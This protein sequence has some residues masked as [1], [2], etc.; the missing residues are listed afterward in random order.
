MDEDVASARAAHTPQ[1]VCNQQQLGVT[2]EFVQRL[3]RPLA[4]ARPPLSDGSL[5]F[6][7][8]LF[9]IN[10]VASSSTM[11]L[12]LSGDF[13]ASCRGQGT[14]RLIESVTHSARKTRGARRKSFN[15]EEKNSLAIV[16][17]ILRIT[18]FCR[19]EIFMTCT[20]VPRP[21]PY[22]ESFCEDFRS[23]TVK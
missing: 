19:R 15:D 5:I 2:L 18:V 7:A 10:R 16:Y 20:N 11:G 9:I 14:A 21:R 3:L 12:F 23:P 6:R 13:R 22:L 4:F 8:E 17:Y 1:R